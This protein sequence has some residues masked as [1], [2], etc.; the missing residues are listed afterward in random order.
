[1]LVDLSSGLPDLARTYRNWK[2]NYTASSTQV[3]AHCSVIYSLF[4]FS[5]HSV[6]LN[7]ASPVSNLSQCVTTNSIS[8]CELSTQANEHPQIIKS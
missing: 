8:I 7:L 2:S 3:V 5:E 4:F 6:Q 1:M